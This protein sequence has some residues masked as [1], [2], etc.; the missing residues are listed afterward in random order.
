MSKECPECYFENDDDAIRCA[1][2]NCPLVQ[3]D[4]KKSDTADEIFVW[5]ILCPVDLAL[6][7]VPGADHRCET[8]RYPFNRAFMDDDSCKPIK[9]KV[10]RPLLI[11]EEIEG[12]IAPKKLLNPVEPYKKINAC[13]IIIA[14]DSIIGREGNVEYFLNDEYVSGLHCEISLVGNNWMVKRLNDPNKNPTCVNGCNLAPNILVIIPDG[15]TLQIA[16]KLFLVTLRGMKLKGCTPETR[17]EPHTA[18]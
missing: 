16:D 6:I 1:M 15:S 13:P 3:L 9:A 7:H 5:Q 12:N 2:C 4:D 10:T 14:E 8:C 11:L 17:E 18:D